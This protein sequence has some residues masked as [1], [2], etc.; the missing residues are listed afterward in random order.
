MRNKLLTTLCTIVISTTASANCVGK[1]VNPFTDICW[2]CM[3]P[4]YIAGIDL[5]LSNRG[6]QPGGSFVAPP[7]C[8]GNTIFGYKIGIGMDYYEPNKIVDVTRTP[9]CMVGLGGVDFSMGIASL[10]NRQ[11]E[12]T[13]NSNVKVN[14]YYHAHT[15]INP[16]LALLE[17]PIDTAC[18]SLGDFEIGYLTELDP[19]W[20]NDSMT[21]WLNPDAV[22]YANPGTLVTAAMDCVSN[23]PGAWNI[24]SGLAYWSAGCQGVMYPLDGN[25]PGSNPI[26]DSIL[27]MQRVMSKLHRQLLEY[28]TAGPTAMFAP[29]VPQPIMNKTEYKYSMVY[30]ITFDDPFSGGKCCSPFGRTTAGWAPGHTFPTMGEDFTYHIYQRR[31]CCS[32]IT[33]PY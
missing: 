2:G 28:S 19:L 4:F 24:S 21:F 17:V 3:F 15:Y 11:G 5:P 12:A 7:V 33:I 31:D 30:P 13:A 23:L 26:D 1:F 16:I 18:S 22:L 29:I 32:G 10:Y 6:E 8:A 25:L 27:T 14:N 9:Y 20:N